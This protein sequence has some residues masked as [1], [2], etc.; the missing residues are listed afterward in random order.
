ML[1]NAIADS[2]NQVP[3]LQLLAFSIAAAESKERVHGDA[4]GAER[5]QGYP[6]LSRVLHTCSHPRN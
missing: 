1:G 2:C 4:E 3:N 5:L 6:R